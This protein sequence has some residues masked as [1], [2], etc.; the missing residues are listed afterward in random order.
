MGRVDTKA[1]KISGF[2]TTGRPPETLL[3]RRAK[4]AASPTSR[5][6]APVSPPVEVLPPEGG[7][8]SDELAPMQKKYKRPDMIG[9]SNWKFRKA[10][11]SPKRLFK[12]P[13]ELWDK[14]DEYFTWMDE[15]PMIGFKVTQTN[16][17]IVEMVEPKMRAMSVSSLCTHLCISRMS[18]DEY[19]KKEEFRDTCAAVELIIYN[20]KFEGAAADML[21]PGIIARELGLK[22]RTDVTSGDESITGI[23]RK[24]IDS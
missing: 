14:A 3:E 7:D 16:G 20:Q 13:Q 5:A 1:D 6:S 4:R 17:M 19:S 18:W 9:N 22:D 12:T 21:N 11:I 8:P 15:N 2:L 23:T 10:T 24:V